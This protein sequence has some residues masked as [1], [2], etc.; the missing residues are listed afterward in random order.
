MTKL[1]SPFSRLKLKNRLIMA[2]MTRCFA[3]PIGHPT[4]ELGKYYIERARGGVGL[5]IVESCSVN[6]ADACGYVNGCQLCLES[7]AAKWRPIVEEVKKYG[8]QIWVQL[9]HAGR[10]TVP[11]ISNGRP[12]ASSELVPGGSN[13]FWRP[14]LNGEIVHFQTL[15]PYVKPRTASPQDISR[16]SNDFQAAIR[17]ASEAGFDGIE[18]HGA[19]GYFLHGLISKYALGSK[20]HNNKGLEACEKIVYSCQRE[21]KKHGLLMSFRISTHMIDNNY[22][23]LK[24]LNL[25][26]FIPRLSKAGVDVFHSS[27]LHVGQPAF[28]SKISLGKAIREHTEKPIIGC[29]GLNSLADAD[30]LLKTNVYDLVAFGR[31]LMKASTIPIESDNKKFDYG[32]HFTS[33]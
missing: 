2:P 27:E 8:T 33:L 17:L 19:H 30:A 13:S 15:T 22:L 18:I 14:E 16:I 29:G 20:D 9:F 26:D 4:P 12:I 32:E 11:E 21:A 24:D 1:L 6:N 28:R 25:S 23:G 3:D 7:H 5:I 31:Q 10:L